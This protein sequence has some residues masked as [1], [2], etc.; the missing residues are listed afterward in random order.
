MLIIFCA[1][2]EEAKNIK[3]S[4]ALIVVTGV[5]VGNVLIKASKFQFTPEDIIINVGYAGSNKYSIGTV[6]GVQSCKRLNPSTVIKEPTIELKSLTESDVC[7]TADDF[8]EHAR[9]E[10][11]LV[12]M[13]LYYL[14]L[15]YPQIQSLKIVSDNLDYKTYKKTNFNKSW[16][17]V[18][19]IL[20]EVTNGK[21]TVF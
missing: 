12:D 1:E 19:K 10:V 5:G 4:D 9:D 16:E 20:N 13:E 14:A 8:I 21:N 6:M 2:L 15:I 18:N 7:Y 11:S 17:T 3:C